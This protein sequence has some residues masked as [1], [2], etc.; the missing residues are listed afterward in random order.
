MVTAQEL[1]NEN[2]SFVLT[3]PL[4]IVSFSATAD[5][6]V[7]IDIRDLFAQIV[8]GKDPGVYEVTGRSGQFQPVI[9]FMPG[10]PLNI[11]KPRATPNAV[12]VK[13]KGPTGGGQIVVI[14]KTGKI[15]L[16]GS[17]IDGLFRFVKKYVPDVTRGSI[18]YNNTTALFGTNLKFM[19]LGDMPRMTYEPEISPFGFL[20]SKTPKCTFL[21]TTK[22]VIHILGAS[23]IDA[24]F[25]WI[26]N[27]LDSVDQRLLRVSPTIANVT[28]GQGKVARKTE[29]SLVTR[30]GTTC[31]KNRCPDPYSYDGK[32]PAGY[33]VRPNPQM[34]PCCYKSKRA[35]I[36]EVRKAYQNAGVNMPN[37]V[38][39]LLGNKSPSPASVMSPSIKTSYDERGALKIGTRQCSRYTLE[40]LK[41]LAE[42]MGIDTTKLKTKSSICDAIQERFP[43]KEPIPFRK[44]FSLNGANYALSRK[45]GKLFINRRV[46]VKNHQTGTKKGAA[47]PRSGIREC[48]T[49]L[50]ADLVKYARAFGIEASKLT[51]SQICGELMKRVRSPSRSPSSASSSGMSNFARSL[52][53]NLMKRRSPSRSPSSA[54]S[55]GMSNFARS[56][57]RN[58][59]KRRSP[60]RSP[61][62]ASS[63]GMSNF[64][65][66]L[67]RNMMKRSSP[68]RKLKKVN[69]EVM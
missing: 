37:S 58:L 52:N 32:C 4:N 48:T 34:F 17:D 2:S 35:K 42:R 50:K 12:E 5:A 1:L 8:V 69:V 59:M 30:K 49:I 66:S 39:S 64:A 9:K 15:R 56:L 10:F 38:R 19:R 24:C 41:T 53:R 31:P 33:Y 22:G 26:K 51:K 23:D 61:S 11:L 46:P 25:D 55:S 68:L 28:L 57:N 44:N 14:Y 21:F 47:G 43:P 63:S 27:Y 40:Q 3:G 67:N 54:S 6:G 16:Q 7:Q 13:I 45:N 62:S 20:R 18:K 29:G 65:R 36:T 60:S